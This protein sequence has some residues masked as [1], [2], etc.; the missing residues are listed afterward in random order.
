MRRGPP[1]FA[2]EYPFWQSFHDRRGVSDAP[3]RVAALG[4]QPQGCVE[5]MAFRS[6]GE[7]ADMA[8]S[9]DATFDRCYGVNRLL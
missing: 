6:P 3:G 9:V 5:G 8:V 2:D 1:G 4:H 7:V